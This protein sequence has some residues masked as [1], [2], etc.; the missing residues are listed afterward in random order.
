MISIIDNELKKLDVKIQNNPINMRPILC[1]ECS[2][3]ESQ[4]AKRHFRVWSTSFNQ[5]NPTQND[6]EMLSPV[7]V[8]EIKSAEDRVDS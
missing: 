2:T 3:Q 8:A 4:M 6:S 1:R 7:K 5:R